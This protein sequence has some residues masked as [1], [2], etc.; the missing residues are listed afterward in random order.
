MLRRWGLLLAWMAVIFWFSH[1]PAEVSRQLAESKPVRKLGHFGG[2]AVL[3]ALA[4]RAAGRPGA[5][6]AIGLLYAAADEWHQTFVPGR[7]G[8]LSD[9]LLDTAG[10]AAGLWVWRRVRCVRGRSRG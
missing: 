1:Q 4:A 2:Y 6:L 10:T 9:V 5:A 8:Q 7:S 3:G